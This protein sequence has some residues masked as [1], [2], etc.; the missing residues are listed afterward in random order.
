MRYRYQANLN[1]EQY[2]KFVDLI[3]NQP[4]TNPAVMALSPSY[5]D[6]EGK[7]HPDAVEIMETRKVPTPH[8]CELIEQCF[9]S[10]IPERI[11]EPVRFESV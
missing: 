1:G 10:Q 6:A 2:Q 11:P 7:F 5:Y 9:G 4:D 3:T 8:V